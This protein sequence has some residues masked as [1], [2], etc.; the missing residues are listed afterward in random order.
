MDRDSVDHPAHYGGK[1]NPHEAIKCIQAHLSVEEFRGFLKGNALKY[2]MRE[3]RKENG[4][5]DLEKAAVYLEWLKSQ[6][7]EEQKQEAEAD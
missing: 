6:A 2:L 5:L 1:D 7:D 4:K 3:G